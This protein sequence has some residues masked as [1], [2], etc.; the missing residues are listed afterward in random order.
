MGVWLRVKSWKT[1][2]SFIP[3]AK[4]INDKIMLITQFRKKDLTTRVGIMWWPKLLFPSTL[5]SSVSK[6]LGF[7]PTDLKKKLERNF[8]D[9]SDLG[10]TD[11]P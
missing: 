11:L 10:G 9:F 6:K 2:T 8:G 7:W 3:P 4:V 1:E 5:Y